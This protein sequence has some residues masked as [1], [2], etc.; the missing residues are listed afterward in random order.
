MNLPQLSYVSEIYMLGLLCRVSTCERKSAKSQSRGI[1]ILS[2]KIDSD[3][4]DRCISTPLAGCHMMF[5]PPLLGM[6]VFI[7][8]ACVKW[9]TRVQDLFTY[10]KLISLFVII[11]VGVLKIV[12]GEGA[13]VSGLE[14]F[15]VC[16]YT[17]LCKEQ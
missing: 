2:P 9:G 8:C 3:V 13:S 11:A 6:L 4:R 17:V 1:F 16:V 7:N 12:Q 10:T 14:G 5:C 15:F